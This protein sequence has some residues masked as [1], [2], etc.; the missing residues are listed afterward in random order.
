MSR[1]TGSIRLDEKDG[2]IRIKRVQPRVVWVGELLAWACVA[3][4]S[5]A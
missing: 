5:E 4:L 2:G 3:S 1:I